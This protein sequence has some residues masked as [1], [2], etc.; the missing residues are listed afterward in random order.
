MGKMKPILIKYAFELRATKKA[1]ITSDVYINLKR[2][3]LDK[4]GE[5]IAARVLDYI[6]DLLYLSR[7]SSVKIDKNDLTGSRFTV[8]LPNLFRELF[9]GSSVNAWAPLLNSPTNDVKILKRYRYRTLDNFLL[10]LT[11][12]ELTD[13]DKIF[14]SVKDMIKALEPK[15]MTN[16]LPTIKQINA[17]NKF[18]LNLLRRRITGS[19]DDNKEVLLAAI[20]ERESILAN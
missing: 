18:Q 17:A 12:V 13:E 5:H 3:L 16:D 6:P 10:Y 15:I 20:K 11:L 9:Y 7:T 4:G 14:K 8:V 1:D 19:D 2:D